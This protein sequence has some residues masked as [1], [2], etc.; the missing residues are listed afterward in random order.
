MAGHNIDR[1]PPASPSTSEKTL[2]VLA[3]A[4]EHARFSE[5]VSATGFPK[6]TVHRII[7]TLVERQFVTVD[8]HGNFLP[9][10][11]ILAMAGKALERIDISSIAQP[12]VDAL[13]EAIHCTVHMGAISG[14]SVVYIMRRDSDKPYTMPS[15]VGHS[16]PLHTTGIGKAILAT[17]DDEKVDQIMRRAGMPRLTDATI[18]SLDEFKMELQD[19]RRRGIARDREENVPG[20]ACIAAPVHDHTGVVRYG[21]SISTLTIEHSEEQI[22]AM[23]DDLLTAAAAISNALGYRTH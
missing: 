22:E 9:G 11:S 20:I 7:S 5:V 21:L 10:P 19:V 16:V 1:V 12:F 15:R 6:A 13:V 2:I 4:L 3:A 18:I 14:D 17:Y 23:A 8:P